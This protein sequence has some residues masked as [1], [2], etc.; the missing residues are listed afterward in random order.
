MLRIFEFTEA[1]RIT[2][3]LS[4]HGQKSHQKSHRSRLHEKPYSCFYSE[5][6]SFIWIKYFNEICLFTVSY[7]V[8]KSS[9]QTSTP[10]EQGTPVDGQRAILL[11]CINL[12]VRLRTHE[13]MT[14]PFSVLIVVYFSRLNEHFRVTINCKVVST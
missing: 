11:T 14:S 12:P 5:I 4:K 7:N 2:D 6:S 8:A 3:G 9:R 10:N 1:T 13:P